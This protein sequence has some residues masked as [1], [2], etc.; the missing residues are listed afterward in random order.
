MGTYG[1]HR[2]A[3]LKPVLRWATEIFAELKHLA[4]ACSCKSAIPL[5]NVKYE[6]SQFSVPQNWNESCPV[7]SV[8]NGQDLK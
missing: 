1:Y 8:Q 4:C 2:K 5:D 3:V 7:F 6:L